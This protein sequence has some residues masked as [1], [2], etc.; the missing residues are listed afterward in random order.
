VI[1]VSLDSLVPAKNELI[2]RRAN[3]QKRA[4]EAI[5]KALAMNRFQAI[6]LN[7]VVMKGFN[8]D[9]LFDFAEF[10]RDRRV[11]LRFIEFMPFD[12]NQWANDKFLSFIESKRMLEEQLGTPLQRLDDCPTSTSKNYGLPGFKGSIGFISSMSD[13]FCGGC[14][15]VRITADGNLKICLFDNREINLKTMID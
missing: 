7:V 14:N 8:D 10:V 6:K 9:E 13:H 11:E 1:N 4:I 15:R 3:T 2:T 12:K 5:D